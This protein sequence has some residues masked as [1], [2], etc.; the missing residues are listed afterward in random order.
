MNAD[1]K[2]QLAE[3]WQA[4]RPYLVDLAF[5]IVGDIGS[6]EDAVQE[7]FSRLAV[8]DFDGI[9]DKRGWLIVVTSRICLDQVRSARSRRER[10]DDLSSG[11]ADARLADQHPSV[12]PADRVTLDDEVRL[13]LLVVLQ[14]LAPAERV[15]FVLHD[16]FQLPFARVAETMNRSAANCRQLARRARLKMQQ[17][18]QPDQ[19]VAARDQQEVG[20]R[21]VEACSSGNI[22]GL[23]A[24]LDPDA[25]G[26]IDLG[27]A[28][29]RTGRSRHGAINVARNLIHYFSGSATLVSNPVGGGGVILAFV[30]RALWAVILLTVVDAQVG[31]VHVIADPQ[32][33]GFINAQLQSTAE[34]R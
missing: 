6:A 4:N 14:R 28:D 9:E 25:S 7:A 33:I 30:D 23:L 12:D 18:D 17:A 32:K 26:D 8:A 3:V 34:L 5:G 13:A 22:D 11:F 10:P 16:V 1:T 21:F 19:A 29:P 2:T 20:Q 15:A 31:E 27:P 24:I